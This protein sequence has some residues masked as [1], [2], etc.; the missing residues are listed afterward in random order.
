M[1]RPLARSAF[2]AKTQ[3]A[4]RN[5]RAID[6]VLRQQE[7]LDPELATRTQ[8][9]RLMELARYAYDNT[10]FYRDLYTAAGITQRDLF[11]PD[12]VEEL[13]LVQK[14]DL[15]D[16]GAE[17]LARG[18]PA[19]R[20]LTSATGGS[21]GVPVSVFHDRNAPVAAMWWRVY[22]WW[23]VAPWDDKAFI[24]RERRSGAAQHRESIQWWPTRHRYLDSR[25]MSAASMRHFYDDL[26]RVKPPLLNGYVG[27]VHEFAA[28]VHGNGLT[29]PS[30]RAIGVTSAPVTD[31]QRTFI[32]S[33][34]GAPVFDQ[35]RTA[36]VPWI[37]AQC[38]E[39]SA[40]HVLSDLRTVEIVNEAGMPSPA[41]T[42]GNVV[43]TDLCN[44]VFPIIRYSIG[45]ISREVEGRCPCGNALKRISAVS[46]RISDVLRLPG[47]IRVAGGLTALFNAHPRAVRQFQIHQRADYSVILRFVLGDDSGARGAVES[48][49]AELA[50]ILGNAVPVGIE[51][52]HSIPHDRGKAR[53]VISDIAN[54]GTVKGT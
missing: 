23:G 22:R 14:S 50:S 40:L 27:G 34:L 51:E 6:R 11:D 41:G 17:F 4:Q 20:R 33:T 54:S 9:A 32:E 12:V 44:R 19:D 15:R 24:Q 49:A 8:R 2:A 36:E 46:G 39:R 29:F 25:E 18:V 3:L 45:D 10:S 28:F 7:N 48:V 47:G 42:D 21:T 52:V 38:R 13:P 26:V 1:T 43:V 5:I 31:S 53:P 35:Y 30:P 37:A 16:H